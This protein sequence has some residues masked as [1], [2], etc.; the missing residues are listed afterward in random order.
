[1]PR[2]SLTYRL[3]NSTSHAALYQ[4]VQLGT[5]QVRE[6][7]AE[8]QSW[9]GLISRIWFWL[10]LL[11]GGER[12]KV[13]EAINPSI[14]TA[15]HIMTQVDLCSYPAPPQPDPVAHLILRREGVS[16]FRQ[17]IAD[18]MLMGRVRRCFT[19]WR[20]HWNSRRSYAV[21][22]DVGFAMS[23]CGAPLKPD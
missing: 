16:R 5:H 12:V 23:L 11:W 9:R 4:S 21:C 8:T 1:M 10:E 17:W 7:V 6:V 20:W 3:S 13:Q 18:N 22:S 14:E 15:T 19:D 2:H